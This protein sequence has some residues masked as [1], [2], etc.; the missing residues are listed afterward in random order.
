M[1][2][3]TKLIAIVASAMI[4][5]SGCYPQGPDYVEELDI[6][7]TH[8]ED[9]YNFSAKQTYSRPDSIVKITGDRQ[10]DDEPEY[11]PDAVATAILATLDKNMAA[12]GYQKVDLDDDPDLLLRPAA[13]ETT[14]IVYY[15]DYWY[16]WYG[17]YYPYWG[18]PAYASSYTSGTLIFSLIDP[19]VVGGNGNPV[20]Q[21]VGAINGILTYSFDAGRVNK[22]IDQ[23]FAQSPYLKTN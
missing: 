14:N 12:M 11:I 7:V 4:F 21:W 8:Y 2:R 1:K 10:G 9:E 20:Q 13:W 15:Y 18:Y 3:K 6:V 19:T 22:A 23:A 5:L 17:G 16:W